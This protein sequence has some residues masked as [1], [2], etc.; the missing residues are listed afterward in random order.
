MN[1]YKSSFQITSKNI[2]G[3]LPQNYRSENSVRQIRQ[4]IRI[5]ISNVNFI[6][7]TTGILENGK[8]K[9][10]LGI[11]KSREKYKSFNLCESISPEINK[12]KCYDLPKK[13]YS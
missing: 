7:Q 3:S 5:P 8:R 2:L 4:S 12:C 9:M 10:C 6:K 11:C 1:S 13:Q